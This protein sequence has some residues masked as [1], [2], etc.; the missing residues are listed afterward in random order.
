MRS[1]AR[2]CSSIRRPTWSRSTSRPARASGSAGWSRPAAC[3]AATISASASRSPTARTTIPVRYQGIVPDLFREGQGVVA[4]GSSSP[5]A[6]SSRHRA[7]QARRALYAEGS[8]RRPEEER[9]LAGRRKATAGRADE[10]IPE[11]GHY[12]LVLAL[13]ARPDPVGRAVDRRAHA[14]RR[15]DGARRR[16]PRSRNSSSS[17]CRLRR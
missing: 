1:G 10:M 16:R 12:A 4:E 17:R 7:R 8:R 14:R 3:S 11:L 2:S 13:G 6:S 9:A 5:A 15:A